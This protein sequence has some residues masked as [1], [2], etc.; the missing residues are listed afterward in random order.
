MPLLAYCMIEAATAAEKPS[1]G[2][3][4]R[5]IEEVENSGLRCFFSRFESRDQIASLPAVEAALAFHQVLQALFHQAV[6]IPFR[7][8]TV[9]D[10]GE[11]LVRHIG[12]HAS[13]HAE[14]LSRLRHMVQMEIHIGSRHEPGT[15]SLADSGREYLQGRQARGAELEAAAKKFRLTTRPWVAEWRERQTA[16]GMRCYA[17]L[18][19][20]A[21]VSFQNA[22]QTLRQSLPGAR[23]SGPW[24]PAEFL[25]VKAS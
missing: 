13:S 19:R 20:E 21:V 23:V 12:E 18:D 16:E 17:L 7:F 14:A 9:V 11:E 4:G 5:K 2:V 15:A 24:P 6:I 1:A 22:A 3:G 25:E 8:P 10:S